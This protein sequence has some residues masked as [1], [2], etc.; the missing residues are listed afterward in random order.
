N[1]EPVA[2]RSRPALMTMTHK[3][4][5]LYMAQITISLPGHPDKATAIV[6]LA[7]ADMVALGDRVKPLSECTLAELSAYGEALE[8]EVWDT[9][10]AISLLMVVDGSQVDIRVTAI[11]EQGH[12]TAEIGDWLKQAI[13]LAPASVADEPVQSEVVA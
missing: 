6:T 13:V 12:Q 7:P 4:D 11:D 1:C 8:A 10:E 9:Y 5:A 2:G 3:Q